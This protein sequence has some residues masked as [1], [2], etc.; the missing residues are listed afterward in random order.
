MVVPRTNLNDAGE[1]SVIRDLPV[2]GIG[3]NFERRNTS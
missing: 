3:E 1:E 2:I